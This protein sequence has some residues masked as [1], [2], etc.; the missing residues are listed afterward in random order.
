[1]VT[2]PCK[3]LVELGDLEFKAGDLFCDT[4]P[5][6]IYRNE[7]ADEVNHILREKLAKAPEVFHSQPFGSGFIVPD[8]P[9]PIDTH[10]GR[11]VCIEEV[12]K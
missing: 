1:M 10:R 8:K 3:C 9:R 11:L 12:G 5:V 4:H 2:S 6:G 7:I